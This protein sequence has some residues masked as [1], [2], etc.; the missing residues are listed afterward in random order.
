MTPQCTQKN[1]KQRFLQKKP[2]TLFLIAHKWKQLDVH[3]L[4][5]KQ[6]T[7]HRV[8][9]CSAIKKN[10]ALIHAAV[11]IIL[12]NNP[13]TIPFMWNGQRRQ[14]HRDRKCVSGCLPVES[15]GGRGGEQGIVANGYEIS[16]LGDG[17]VLELGCG[18]VCTT[19]VNILKTLNCML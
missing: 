13:Y 11:L 12:E 1:R 17:D 3:K 4:M 19:I 10:E 5:G 15:V 14:I 16:F 6:V 9:C 2:F 18:D 7:R 8:G